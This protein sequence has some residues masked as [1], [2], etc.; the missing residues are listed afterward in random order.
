MN[1]NP[2]PNFVWDP[3]P[4]YHAQQCCDN[5]TTSLAETNEP[6]AGEQ[7]KAKGTKKSFILIYF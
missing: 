1:M 6:Q 4:P 7:K 2:I 3:P 5:V